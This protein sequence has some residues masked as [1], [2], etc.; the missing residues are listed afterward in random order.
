MCILIISIGGISDCPSN[1]PPVSKFPNFTEPSGLRV[2]KNFAAQNDNPSSEDC[3]ALNIW[4][5]NPGIS[6][7]KPVLVWFHGGRMLPSAQPLLV[8]R[9]PA[10]EPTGFTIPGPHSPFF[11]GQYLADAEDVVVVTVKSVIMNPLFHVC[12][13]N[14]YPSYRLGIFGF[15]GAPGLAQNV[16]LLDQRSAV[17]W[18]RDNIEAFGGDPSRITIFGQSA[19]GA[20]V[21][22]YSFAWTDDPIVAGLI[23]QSGTALSFLPNTKEYAESLWYN[24]TQAL[25]CGGRPSDSDPEEVQSRILACVRAADVTTI[26]AAA[27]KFPALPTQALPQALPQATFHPTVDN[28]TVFA[29]YE[30]RAAAG[31]F[32]RI[33]LL[34]G[35]NDFEAGWYKL[36]AYAARINLTEA[37]WDLYDERAFTCPSAYTAEYRV[38]YDVPT[39]RYRYFGDWDNLRLYNN[40]AGLGPRGSGAYHG[41]E[42][43][44]VFGTAADVSGLESSY[45]E[46]AT[47][48]YM[49]GAWVAFARDPKRGLTS[50]GWPLYDPSGKFFVLAPLRSRTRRTRAHYRRFCVNIGNTLVRLGY[51]NSP[52]PSFVAPITYDNHCPTKNDPLPGRGAF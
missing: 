47:S 26:L 45:E 34:I 25:G 30:S 23:P 41:S 10:N 39:W 12:R 3:L 9:T 1:K 2:W 17:E 4:T 20:S 29:D 38:R 36:S 35:N 8:G 27:A 31:R 15:S 42:N 16:A 19:G 28:I 5:K 40:S 32:A 21:D 43:E 11:N 48:R 18:V 14:V 44:M 6:V 7:K 24:V 46:A 50:Y 51:Q 52:E 49:M 33:P 22:Y 37:Q 13:I